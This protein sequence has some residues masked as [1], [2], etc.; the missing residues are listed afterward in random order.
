VEHPRVPPG[1]RSIDYL[2]YLSELARKPN[3]AAQVA[4]LLVAQLGAP[5]PQFWGR[6]LEEKGRLEGGRL[7]SLVL[8]TVLKE[9]L[10]VARKAVAVALHRL[11][12][13]LLGAPSPL[14]PPPNTVPPHL[15]LIQVESSDLRIYDRLGGAV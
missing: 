4:P 9:G 14:P 12:L 7:L 6:L 15:A 5:F 8:K 13:N 11:D 10:E 1:Q 2:H 3:A